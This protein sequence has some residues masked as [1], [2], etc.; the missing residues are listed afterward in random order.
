MVWT[1]DAEILALQQPIC[2]ACTQ[3]PTRLPFCC[4]RVIDETDERSYGQASND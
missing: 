3:D 1:T 2:H 4:D